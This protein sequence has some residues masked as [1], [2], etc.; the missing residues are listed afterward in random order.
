MTSFFTSLSALQS[1]QNWIEVLGNNLANATTPGFKGS[2]ATF[3]DQF[4]QTL[5]YGSAPGA[6]LG[7]TNPS[8]IGLGVRL[9]SVGRDFQQGALTTTGRA[10]DMAIEGRSFFTLSDGLRSLYTRVGTFGLDG[11]GSLVDQRSGLHV[12][13]ADGSPISIDANKKIPPQA[14]GTLSISGNLPKVGN[15]PNPEIL[16]N[17]SLATGTNAVLAG[18][19]A[20]PFT[21]PIGET[22]T[23]RVRVSGGPTQTASVTS[24]TGT[25]TAAEIATAIDGLSGVHAADDGS[26]HVVITTDDKG[27]AA[28]IDVDPGSGGHDLAALAG[29]STT[30]VAGTETTVMGT[31]DLSGL[32][33]NHTAYQIGDQIQINGADAD[34]ST[35]STVFTYGAANDG[36]TLQ[37]LVDFLNVVYPASTVALDSNG[38][39]SVTADQPGAAHMQLVLSDAAG[40]TGDT[41]WSDVPFTTTQQGTDPD[42]VTSSSQVFDA[43][44]TAH[45]LTWTFERQADETWNATASMLPADGVVLSAPITGIAFGDD[46]TPQGFDGLAQ[47]LSVQF[48]GQVAVQTVQVSLGTDGELDGLTQFG[49]DGSPLVVEQNGYAAGDLTS[50]SVDLTGDIKGFYSNGQTQSVALMGVATFANPEG[51]TDLGGGMFAVGA[52]SGE[53]ILG[54]G[55]ENGAGRVLG[56]TL[57]QSNVDTASQ[58]VLLIEAQRGYQ[59]N[60]KVISAQDEVLRTTVNMT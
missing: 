6:G 5:R 32:V 15:G 36:T 46:G 51:L 37:D 56:G 59:A 49:T 53:A 28:T 7:G 20:E 35:V 38:N 14:T 54:G 26:G 13:G 19:V 47:T 40:N 8:Q 27:A 52:N 21:I 1:N 34:G 58:L 42:Q 39:I 16:S 41:T 2:Y 10:F 9:A 12:V 11:A 48:T 50:M 43:A 29:L 44:G 45:V 17:T 60:A 4:S 23:L 18:S 57:E 55:G 30:L 25:V 24:T 31:T 33:A 3:A 22:W